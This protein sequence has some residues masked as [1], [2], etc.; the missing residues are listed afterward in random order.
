MAEDIV[1]ELRARGDP[2]SM[3]AARYIEVKR[4]WAAALEADRHAAAERSLRQ[5]NGSGNP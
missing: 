5:D 2:L 1:D 3:R 4:S